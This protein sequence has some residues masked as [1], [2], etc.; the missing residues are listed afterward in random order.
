[1]ITQTPNPEGRGGHSLFAYNDKLY[2]YGG[3]NSETQYNNIVVFDLNT[4][5]WSDPDIYNDVSRW[6][7]SAIMVEAIPT[8]KYFI[9]G[10]ESTNFNEGQDRTFG[11][12]V[13]SACYL[14]IGTMQW[15]DIKPENAEAPTPREYAYQLRY[16]KFP[17]DCFRWLEQWLVE[18]HVC[19]CC[20]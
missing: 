12:Y 19:P 14:D 1:V 6:N 13:N 17:F 9:F 20:Q 16:F 7:H 4:N 18:R 8:W 5:E 10:G 11:A 15:S 2:S 3:W